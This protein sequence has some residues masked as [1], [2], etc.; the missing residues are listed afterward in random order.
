MNIYLY[1]LF[2][3]VSLISQDSQTEL[4]MIPNF[5]GTYHLELCE[6]LTFP[7]YDIPESNLNSF[8]DDTCIFTNILTVN[9][10]AGS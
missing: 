1:I 8:A 10:A 4:V 2:S 9:F 3:L 6:D 7:D 5:S